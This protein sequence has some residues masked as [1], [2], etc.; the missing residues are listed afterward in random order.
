MKII[1]Q[2]PNLLTVAN[3]L[4]GVLGIINVFE[5][6]L[7]NTLY[8]VIIAA[9]FDFFDGFAARLLNVAS[10]M[11]KELDSFADA[12]SFVVLPALYLFKYTS[13]EQAPIW[14]SYT[15]IL[16]AIF[17]VIRLAK[18][19]LDDDQTS[20]FLGLP[21]P[22]A[23]FLTLT[24][25]QLSFITEWPF[26]TFG[27]TLIVCILM[28]APIK[29]INF[30]FKHYKW[31]GNELK[32]VFIFGMLLGSLIFGAQVIPYLIPSYI[33]TSIAGTLFLKSTFKN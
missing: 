17:A 11:G 5:G 9:I 4:I 13:I 26:F 1:K 18:F 33:I 16:I 22:A 23:A 3:L 6:N 31:N 25:T 19:N 10:P 28:T 29:I 27:Y 12:I 15:A 2:I 32:F 8:F 14:L 21:T 24:I 30:K 20:Y 7:K